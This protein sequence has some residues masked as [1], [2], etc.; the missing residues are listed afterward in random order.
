[1]LL[2]L[3]ASQR[4][5]LTF[6][7]IVIFVILIYVFWFFIKK[8]LKHSK[9]TKYMSLDNV[10]T[11][12]KMKNLIG[13]AIHQGKNRRFSLMM[14]TIDH[15][16]QILDYANTQTT[17]EYIQRV[18]KLLE[19]SLPLGGKLAQTPERESF[20]VFLPDDYDKNELHELAVRFKAMAERT[21]EMNNGSKISKSASVSLIQ[22]PDHVNTVEQL[23]H[24]LQTTTYAIKKQGGNEIMN[25]SIDMLEELSNFKTYKDLIS[26]IKKKNIKINFIPIYS[27]KSK[28]MIGAE[29]DCIWMKDDSLNHFIDFMPNLETSNDSY[30]FGLWILEKALSS[31]V[32]MIGL[33]NNQKYELM[34]PVG[35]RQFENEMIAEDLMHI[36]DKYNLKPSQLILKVINP[37]QVNKETQF[38][39]SLIELQSFGVKL[40][41]DIHKIDDSMY[42]L[43][44][45]Y[46]IDVLMLNQS[47]LTLNHDKQLEVEEL[48]NF[49]KANRLEMIV[50]GVSDKNQIAKLDEDIIKIQGS[51]CSAPLSKE[52]IINQLNKKLD[53]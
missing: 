48:V 30:W 41:L 42:Y 1:M 47:L 18:G 39:K 37:L 52:Q 50:T 24:G 35:V 25:Y 14:V 51:L 43:L 34:V 49:S 29:I 31:H 19:I 3:N 32:S 45:E 46:K 11:Y 21:I 6:A 44:N 2:S 12:K 7:L 10:I 22:Y 4:Q 28:Y 33:N 15:F 16:E 20:I 40:S 36:L 53:I 13:Y 9:K 5:I 8:E 38:I 17:T 23:I 27:I 26:A